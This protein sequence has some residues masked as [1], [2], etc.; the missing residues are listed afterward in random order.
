MCRSVCIRIIDAFLSIILI[1]LTLPVQL[2]L[3]LLI[4]ALLKENPVFV[5]ER[6]IT[7]DSKRFALFK[8]RTIGS[9]QRWMNSTP[10]EK[11]RFLSHTADFEINKTLSFIRR[12]G[13]DELPQLY[14][15][16]LGQMNFIGPRPL[17]NEDLTLMEKEF[18]YYNNLRRSVKSKPG[19]TG[20]WQIYGSRAEGIENL[21]HYDLLFEKNKSLRMNFKIIAGTLKIILTA[22]NFDS[23]AENNH[24]KSH[25]ISELI[26]SK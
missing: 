3:V 9:K 10:H 11:I 2:F 17:M 12:T 15:V 20:L 1:L 26:V 18:P 7:S 23:G 6:G 22:S 14:N 19:I 13:L 16:L 8:F 24:S 4:I 21:I 25:D 5:Q